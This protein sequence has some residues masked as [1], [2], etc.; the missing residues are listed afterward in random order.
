MAKL[1]ITTVTIQVNLL[2]SPSTNSLELF[3]LNVFA[4]YLQ[5]QPFLG[6][7]LGFH[8][9]NHGFLGAVP[10]FYSLAVLD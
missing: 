10:Y 1:L 2:L 7:K 5:S 6:C 8:I 3:L 9:F 4:V